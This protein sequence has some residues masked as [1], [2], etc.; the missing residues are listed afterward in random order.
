MVAGI[1]RKVMG[2]M[3][4]QAMASDLHEE[5]LKFLKASKKSSVMLESLNNHQKI[6]VIIA[7]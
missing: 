5:I 3:I 1:S 2:D 7:L 4:I 6:L